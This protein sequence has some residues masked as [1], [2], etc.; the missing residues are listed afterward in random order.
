MLLC[1]PLTKTIEIVCQ[2]LVTEFS[3]KILSLPDGNKDYLTLL[4]AFFYFLSVFNESILNPLGMSDYS[5][6]DR[7]ILASDM[8]ETYGPWMARLDNNEGCWVMPEAENF[9]QVDL[10]EGLVLV[11]GVATQGCYNTEHHLY[12]YV[13]EYL[14]SFSDDGAE[15]Y[16]YQEQRRP[17]VF[18]SKVGRLG[19]D[20]ALRQH[21]L[22]IG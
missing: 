20:P 3:S 9:L 16:Y 4:L 21:R 22:F 5:I 2:L 10:G 19:R 7:S 12:G 18:L 1:I 6:A 8:Y 11:T 17:K 13:L 15:W 14:L